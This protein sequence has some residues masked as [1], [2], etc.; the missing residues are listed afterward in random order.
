M[1]GCA[2]VPPPGEPR[3][4][5][6][7]PPSLLGANSM[8][9]VSSSVLDADDLAELPPVTLSFPPVPKAVPPFN[10]APF[11]SGQIQWVVPISDDA[12]AF[13]R[14]KRKN[15]TGFISRSAVLLLWS[16]IGKPHVTDETEKTRK[17]GADVC[18]FSRPSGVTALVNRHIGCCKMEVEFLAMKLT[19]TLKPACRNCSGRG[20]QAPSPANRSQ[21]FAPRRGGSPNCAIHRRSRVHPSALT[22]PS[23][24][25]TC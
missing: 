18:D 1:S 9:A 15:M 24:W 23:E 5:C 2:D 14:R 22:P 20:A 7:L 13:R 3:R 6:S 8:V 19:K 25:E 11:A 4:Q 21:H 17:S 12:E 10:L 16:E